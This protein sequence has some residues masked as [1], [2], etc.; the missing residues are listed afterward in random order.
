MDKRLVINLCWNKKSA[1]AAKRRL[2][3]SWEENQQTKRA[4]YA[5]RSRL[6]SCTCATCSR[7]VFNLVLISQNAYWK[8]SKVKNELHKQS[9]EELKKSEKARVKSEGAKCCRRR[10]GRQINLC[11][12][13]RNLLPRKLDPLDT[14]NEVA[15]VAL[16]LTEFQH[17]LRVGE[18]RGHS[19]LLN[20]LV[21][22]WRSETRTFHLPIGEVT[23]TLEDVSY[24][25][26]LPINGEAITDRSDSS[27]QFLVENCIACFGR[28]P[29]P[30]DHVFG[31]VNI[32]W[33]GRCRDIEPCDTQE[34]L[35]R[36]GAAS[37]AHLYRSLRRASRYNCKEMDGPLILLFVWA[38]KRMPFLAPIP[39]DQLGDV[40]VPLV[41][42]WSHWHRHTRYIRRLTAY[43]RRG[44]DDMGV[45]DN[46]SNAGICPVV[47]GSG[48]CPAVSGPGICPAV[49]GYSICPTVAGISAACSIHTGIT[50]ASGI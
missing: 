50:A 1:A 25:L 43:F 28:E 36:W 21:K 13:I 10:T 39:R 4:L 9:E 45:D 20:A 7:R 37:L 30:E 2:R 29:G 6:P 5:D 27:H 26:G 44:L 14:F 48:I 42:R 32:V 38:W 24:I 31:K 15:A 16:A 40:G 49:S 8:G 18:M 11:I 47:S 19:A 46:S 35:E 23:V 33:V 34:S 3:L 12:A 41:Q 17:V 22:R